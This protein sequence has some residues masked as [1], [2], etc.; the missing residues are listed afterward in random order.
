LQCTGIVKAEGGQATVKIKVAPIA[1]LGEHSFRVVT[2][3]GISDVRLFYVSPFPGQ[4]SVKEKDNPKKP[5]TV[6]LGTTIY[7]RTQGENQDSFEVD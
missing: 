2:S 1:A 7:G 6:A 3:S 4:R 5:Q